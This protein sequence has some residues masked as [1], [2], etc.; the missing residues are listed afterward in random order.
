[1]NPL[2]YETALIYLLGNKIK[3]KFRDEAIVV[4]YID[5]TGIITTTEHSG[6]Q[7]ERILYYEL[8][9]NYTFFNG[10]AIGVEF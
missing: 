7:Q 6:W 8:L 4:S 9:Q 2:S 10:D 1:M 3:H 5:N